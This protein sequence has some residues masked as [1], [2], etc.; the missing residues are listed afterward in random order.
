[1]CL[2][3]PF[4][5]HNTATAL[6]SMALHKGAVTQWRPEKKFPTRLWRSRKCPERAWNATKYDVLYP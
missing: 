4:L 2:T 6:G 3:A 5:P 1:M